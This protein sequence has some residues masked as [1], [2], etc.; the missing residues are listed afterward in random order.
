MADPTTFAYNLL[1][2]I[3]SRIELT[4]DAILH[5]SP[6]DMESYMHLVGELQGLE[7]SQR[8]IKDLLQ[9]TEEE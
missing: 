4:Q 5:G 1:R 8:E 6:K 2:A 3:E 9:T 7:F